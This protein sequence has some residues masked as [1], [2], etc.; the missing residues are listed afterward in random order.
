M[1]THRILLSKCGY[2]NLNMFINCQKKNLHN[3]VCSSGYIFVQASSLQ[4]YKIFHNVAS[5]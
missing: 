4:G 2:D 5:W 3:V 1:V